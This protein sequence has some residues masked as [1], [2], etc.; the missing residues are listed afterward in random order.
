MVSNG[1]QWSIQTSDGHSSQFSQM[2][3]KCQSQSKMKKHQKGEK[4]QLI[5]INL[6]M[7]LLIVFNNDLDHCFDDQNH[8]QSSS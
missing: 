6:L 1:Q 8:Y 5:M 7:I 3:Q 4:L 2:Q